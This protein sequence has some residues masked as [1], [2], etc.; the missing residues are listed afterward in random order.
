MDYI[1]EVDGIEN[2]GVGDGGDKYK[3]G[4]VGSV[5]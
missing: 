4:R 2:S 3:R 5:L 1:E